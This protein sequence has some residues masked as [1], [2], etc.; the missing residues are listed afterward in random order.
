[1]RLVASVA[2]IEPKPYGP[3]STRKAKKVSFGPLSGSCDGGS[4]CMETGRPCNLVCKC[5]LANVPSLPLPRLACQQDA[6]MPAA[7]TPK[8]HAWKQSGRQP[9]ETAQLLC[10]ACSL[11]MASG[12]CEVE[13]GAGTDLPK[14][15][16]RQQQNRE[17]HAAV[18]KGLVQCSAEINSSGGCLDLRIAP[19]SGAN[20]VGTLGR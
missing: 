10:S 19:G 4:C 7:F 8:Q 2:V 15:Q 14:A 9:E 5:F 3:L 11:H 20:R 17:T 1:M 12:Q 13:T 6:D 16:T 18:A